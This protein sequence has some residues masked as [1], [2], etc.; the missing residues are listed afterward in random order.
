MRTFLFPSTGSP[1]FKKIDRIYFYSYDD[2]KKK[3]K[4]DL[5]SVPIRQLK[6]K[7]MVLS[8]TMGQKNKWI[9]I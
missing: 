8:N 9:K 5:R 4:K 7:I 3:K 6:L 1:L 2:H